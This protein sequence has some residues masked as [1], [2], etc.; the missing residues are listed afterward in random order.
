MQKKDEYQ[1]ELFENLTALEKKKR[2]RRGRHIARQYR[3]MLDLSYEQIIFFAI[4][5]IM[6][7]VLVFSA[8]MEK[9]RAVV[10]AKVSPEAAAPKAAVKNIEP[11]NEN[12]VSE[13]KSGSPEPEEEPV[14]EPK[15]PAQKQKQA[16]VGTASKPYTI[17]VAT[18]WSKPSAK[19][20][21]EKLRKKGFDS[22][23]ISSNGK[24][25]VCTGEYISKEGAKK[26]IEALKKDYKDLFL[27][28]R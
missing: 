20:E 22:F 13:I 26:N 2:V 18:Y 25:E 6:V 3:L 17:Q 8:G 16:K 21:L 19:K 23:I 12:L 7:M 27:R 11:P 15:K 24:Y 5:L 28:R 1:S 14:A 10:T 9:G 4:A